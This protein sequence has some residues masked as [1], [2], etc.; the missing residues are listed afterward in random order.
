MSR[1]AGIAAV[2]EQTSREGMSK[3]VWRGGLGDFGRTVG[4]MERLLNHRLVQVVAMPQS[5]VAIRMPFGLGL[6][7]FGVACGLI[8]FCV[9]SS[10]IERMP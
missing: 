5:G 7:D 10:E 2:F 9:L 8:M 3:G 4:G 1:R 6:F